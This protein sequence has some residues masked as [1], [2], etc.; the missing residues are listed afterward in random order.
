MAVEKIE[1][2]IPIKA[3]LHLP[4]ILCVPPG[5]DAMVIFSHGSGSSRYS[6]RNN[7][8]AGML[9]KERIATL[10]TDLLTEDEDTIYENRFDI[11]LLSN[12]LAEVT[13]YIHQSTAF[14]KFRLGYFG[15]STG[16]AS[17]LQAAARLHPLIRAIVSRG[18]RPDLAWDALPSVQAPTLLIVGTLDE[19]VLALNEQAFAL[20]ECHKK[21]E[22]VAGASHLFE[23]PG[24][25]E[26]V[27]ELAKNWFTEFLRLPSASKSN[28]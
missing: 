12:R 7:V 14:S 15:A 8:V 23:E 24:K 11:D 26:L 19:D 21:L 9:N 22:L 18:G 1:I 17:A 10:L 16:S 6:V 20:L 28:A 2:D 4:A 27:S 25:L 13:E 5:A 3:G